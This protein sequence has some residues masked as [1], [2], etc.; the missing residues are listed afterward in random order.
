MEK[1][2]K[3]IFI[4]PIRFYQLLISPIIGGNRCCRFMP[5]CSSYAIE[6]IERMGVTKGVFYSTIRIF[7]CNPWGGKGYDPVPNK[8]SDNK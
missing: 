7:R 5:S 4:L 1:V 3:K 2:I 6:A 8:N